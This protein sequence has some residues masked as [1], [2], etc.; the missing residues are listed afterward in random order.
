MPMP[1]NWNRIPRTSRKPSIENDI[2]PLAL[3]RK[4]RPFARNLGGAHAAA[5]YFT[6]ISAARACGSDPSHCGLSLETP[7]IRAHSPGFS[8]WLGGTPSANQKKVCRP[9]HNFCQSDH[10]RCSSLG[11]LPFQHPRFPQPRG[12]YAVLSMA[13]D[14]GFASIR[15]TMG[16]CQE[17]GWVLE[18][19]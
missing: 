5:T 14:S 9:C 7:C 8:T 16:A 15:P 17:K 3:G 4:N 18:F 2:Q 6:L 1:R 12:G 19:Q 13:A 11:T 10:R